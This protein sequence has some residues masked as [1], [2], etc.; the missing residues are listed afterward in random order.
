MSK[1]S[2]HFCPLV[3]AG[4]AAPF[5]ATEAEEEAGEIAAAKTANLAE[6][7]ILDG[8]RSRREA[9]SYTR[10]WKN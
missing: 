2:A 10:F 5:T 1:L 7:G 8:G 6:V 9:N 3:R 4:P